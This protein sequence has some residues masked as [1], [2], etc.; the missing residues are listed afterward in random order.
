VG[1]RHDYY[2]TSESRYF[3]AYDSSAGFFLQ[4]FGDGDFFV[5][6]NGI[7]VLDLG[8]VHQQTPGKVVVAGGP[9]PTQA[10]I[11]EGGCLD[12]DGNI[13]TTQAGY[14]AAGCTSKSATNVPAPISPDDFRIRTANL[15]MNNGKVYEVAIFGADR[16]QAESNLQLTLNGSTSKRSICQR[17]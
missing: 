8:G 9:G 2:F 15:N 3:F 13:T 12:A 1:V 10:T 5:F 14:L 7:L 17:N 6:I 11:M 4:F 16:H